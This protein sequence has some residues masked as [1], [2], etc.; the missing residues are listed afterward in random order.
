MPGRDPFSCDAPR[1]LLAG[2]GGFQNRAKIVGDIFGFSN[3]CKDEASRSP[4]ERK[5]IDR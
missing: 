1:L 3:L 4:E 2:V 5:G